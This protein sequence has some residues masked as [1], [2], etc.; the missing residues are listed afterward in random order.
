MCK[1]LNEKDIR[2]LTIARESVQWLSAARAS[3][4]DV[5]NDAELY[6]F[7]LEHVENEG[8][9]VKAYDAWGGYGE[10]SI[11]VIGFASVFVVQALD[12]ETEDFH[13]SL[14]EALGEAEEI[15]SCYQPS[16]D[17]DG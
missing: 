5:N 11:D 1:K 9:H 13:L 3:D 4:V 14:E 17:E 10:F 7:C 6:D 8:D 12:I 15:A 2:L 16:E